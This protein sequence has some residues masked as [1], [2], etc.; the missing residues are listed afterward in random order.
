M[1]YKRPDKEQIKKDLA[2]IAEKLEKA[3]TYIEAKAAFIEHDELN[4]HMTTQFTLASI[5]NSVDTRDEFYD[6]EVKY[7]NSASPEIAEYEQM[8]VAALLKSPFRKE[9]IA[10]Y[11]DRMFIDAEM[12]IK[13]FSPEIIPESQKENDLTRE[14]ENLLA[15][16]QIE[17]DGGVYTLSQLTPFKTSADDDVRLRA[18]TAEGA[19]YKK[20]QEKLDSIYDELVSL[21]DTMGRKM[22]YKGSTRNLDITV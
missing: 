15:S 1:Q 8:F 19:W 12:Q 9:F 10:D 21:R 6:A 18:W 7:S 4:R 20:N 22:G 17:F 3:K 5:R 13:A 11:G 14:Y 16:A 2:A